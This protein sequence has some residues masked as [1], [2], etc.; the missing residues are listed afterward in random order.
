M[1]ATPDS[2]LPAL[3]LKLTG[4]ALDAAVLPALLRAG[5]AREASTAADPFLAAGTFEVVRA[6]DLSPAGRA[7]VDGVHDERVEV[8]PGQVLVLELADG[9]TLV[10]SA[11]RLHEDLQRVA[12]D[13][14]AT[15]TGVLVLDRVRPRGVVSRGLGDSLGRLVAKLF[16]LDRGAASDAILDEAIDKVRD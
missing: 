12:P 7:A 6:F 15:E 2:D 4:R 14:G 9:T 11:A 1:A 13:A 16:V 8:H 5:P 3:A 10:T